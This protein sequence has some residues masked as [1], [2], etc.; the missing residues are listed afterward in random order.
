MMVSSLVSFAQAGPE[1]AHRA[2][3]HSHQADIVLRKQKRADGESVPRLKLFKARQTA[4]R[5]KEPTV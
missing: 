2:N 1:W 5:L 4:A 3:E